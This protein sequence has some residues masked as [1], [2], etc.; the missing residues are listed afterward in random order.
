MTPTADYIRE[1]ANSVVAEKYKDA[2]SFIEGEARN[3]F[4][5]C[6]LVEGQH[7]AIA[8]AIDL[9]HRIQEFGDETKSVSNGDKPM[10]IYVSWEAQ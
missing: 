5:D 6:E 9:R 7:F 4:L 8:S 1:I 10:R 2:F 3:G